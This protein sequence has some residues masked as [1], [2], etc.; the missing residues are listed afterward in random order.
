MKKYYQNYIKY[1]EVDTLHASRIPESASDKLYNSII[2][3]EINENNKTEMDSLWRLIYK[4]KNI[5][6]FVQIFMQLKKNL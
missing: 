2:R 4:G 5:I 3:I 1:D 6:F